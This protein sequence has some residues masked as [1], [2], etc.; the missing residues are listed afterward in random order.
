MVPPARDE[1]REAVTATA[2]RFGISGVAVGV[3]ADGRE[4]Y[5]CHGVTSLENPLPVDRD[6]LYV[7]GSVTKS[8]T[9]TALSRLG[10]AGSDILNDAG[11]A[12]SGASVLLCWVSRTRRG[13]HR[14]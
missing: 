7:Q 8:V 3:R 5:A 13:G 12:T 6:T 4:E 11:L 1:L 10:E 2:T 9:A 14:R